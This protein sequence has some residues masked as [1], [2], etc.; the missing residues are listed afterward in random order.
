M[1]LEAQQ[2]LGTLRVVLMVNFLYENIFG[3]WIFSSSGE[4][5]MNAHELTLGNYALV[6]KGF[7]THLETTKLNQ[8][9]KL[10]IA[11]IQPW[12]RTDKP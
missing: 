12:F 2:R 8:V 4:S 9:S 7:P 5:V 6:A 11:A 1:V 3:V 10:M